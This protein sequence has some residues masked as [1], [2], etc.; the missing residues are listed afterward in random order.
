MKKRL[1][2]Y[3]LCCTILLNAC[4]TEKGKNTPDADTVSG[5]A[6]QNDSV[7]QS[8]DNAAQDTDN[9]AQD[10]GSSSETEMYTEISLTIQNQIP[11][12]L[13]QTLCIS[14]YGQD[15]WGENIL[16]D[17]QITPKGSVSVRVPLPDG[18]LIW[19]IKTTG[20]SKGQKKAY[21]LKFLEL[22]LTECD[23]EPI[24]VTLMLDDDENPIAIAQ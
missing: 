13:V 4:G 19:D 10:T 21:T 23:S 11:N 5:A 20:T 15:A 24:I 12:Y 16:A 17:T 18:S 8:T 1:L 14:A 6:L 22:D 2:F 7:P 9:A 3:F